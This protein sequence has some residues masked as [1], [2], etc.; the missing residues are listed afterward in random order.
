MDEQMYEARVETNNPGFPWYH[1]V[2]MARNSAAARRKVW[3]YMKAR[4]PE[5][6]VKRVSVWSTGSDPE[7]G[8]VVSHWDTHK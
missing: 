1:M 8:M 7:F 3:A 2:L 6:E 5:T 4:H